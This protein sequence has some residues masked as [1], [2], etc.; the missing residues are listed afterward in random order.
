MSALIPENPGQV[1]PAMIP[2]RFPALLIRVFLLLVSGLAGRAGAATA[3][4]LA[5]DD[6]RLDFTTASSPAGKP[7][8]THSTSALCVDD[9]DG[10]RSPALSPGGESWIQATV[11]GPDK[12]DFMW[13]LETAAANT[14]TCYLDG[15]PVAACTGDVTA[16]WQYV[17]ITIPA[18]SHTLRWTYKQPGFTAGRAL[19]DLVGHA[20]DAAPSITENPEIQVPL[21]VPVS[22]TLQTRQP[23]FFWEVLF[24]PLPPGLA[25][26]ALTGRIT[27]TP[28][29]TGIWRPLFRINSLTHT[30]YYRITIEVL[31]RPTIYGVLDSRSLIFTTTAS[32]GTS[33][34]MPQATGSRD[35]GDCL[36]A[37][38]PPPV[39]R[40]P[41]YK[42]GWS[43]VNTTVS[44]PDTLSYWSDV[45][46][47][48]IILLL[49]D[50]EVRSH[51]PG[52]S[53]RGWQRSW[54]PIPSG[55]HRVTWRY[56]P[57]LNATPSAL[58]DDVRLLSE[59]RPFITM[60]PNISPLESGTL[61]FPVAASG[62]SIGWIPEG[63]PEG[64]LFNTGTGTLTGSP[65]RRG[66]WPLRL[67]LNADGGD[68]DDVFA[69]LDCSI[70]ISDSLDW[71]NTWWNPGEEP[72]TRWFGQNVITRDGTDAVRSPQ[73]PR[74]K[75]RSLLTSVSGPGTLRWWWHI[76]AASAG[77]RC[78]FSIDSR[79]R[80]VE[81]A[82]PT[83]WKQEAVAI[84]AGYHNISWRWVTDEAGDPAAEA[85]I[86]DNV[87]LTP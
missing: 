13:A 4:Q 2:P 25:L 26:D 28:L 74:G 81:I 61:N 34:W 41:P 23:A 59:G 57:Y 9:T 50:R 65:A 53:V 82:G 66:I 76:P 19:I 71:P 17:A 48:R 1:S 83:P 18:G 49:D 40:T 3:L 42:P 44:G 84:P 79:P 14:F 73:T 43:A 72:S 36:C 16:R 27:G 24:D 32:D 45:K 86:L 62:P 60:E 30:L 39:Q 37:G 22:R 46:S 21:G 20:A 51:G 70:P 52:K 8:I 38:T 35:D 67:R 77:D 7:W 31:E 85:V 15:V 29:E 80:T 6:T 54:L 87:S 33:V 47:G 11:S 75:S 63:L 10:A 55:S 64:V 12:I 68:S 58:L 56:E 69:T 78:A 5:L